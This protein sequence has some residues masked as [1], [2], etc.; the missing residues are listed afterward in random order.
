MLSWN[1]ILWTAQGLWLLLRRVVA[2]HGSKNSGQELFCSCT[3][4]LQLCDNAQ[5]VA[6]LII[7]KVDQLQFLLSKYSHKKK[8]KNLQLA[9][10]FGLYHKPG[11]LQLS[12]HSL[13]LKKKK[14]F[15]FAL[16]KLPITIGDFQKHTACPLIYILSLVSFSC[17]NDLSQSSVKLLSW[18]YLHIFAKCF[19]GFTFHRNAK[20]QFNLLLWM[21]LCYV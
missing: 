10:S 21:Y 4:T 12:G 17:N 18:K 5:I 2:F 11:V 6:Y 9:P 7:N 14:C 1:L 8:K 16:E 19:F 15:V 13:S 20:N 3:V